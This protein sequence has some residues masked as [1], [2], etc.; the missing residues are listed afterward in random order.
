M[1]FFF[2]EMFGPRI[3]R[4]M[5]TLLAREGVEFKRLTEKF[6]SGTDDGFWIRPLGAEKGWIILSGDNKIWKNSH[7]RKDLI[8]SGLTAFIFPPSF[9]DFKRFDRL[10]YIFWMWPRISELANRNPH[11]HIYQLYSNYRI[12]L[13]YHP[14]K[15]PR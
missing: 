2:D 6:P 11:E 12:R 3:V 14:V 9:S 1:K 15:Q 8:D 10:R 7:E 13:K 4:L 5:N